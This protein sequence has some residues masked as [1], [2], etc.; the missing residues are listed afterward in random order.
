MSEDP[1]PAATTASGATPA[2]DTAAVRAD[3]MTVRYQG[4]PEPAVVEVSFAVEPGCGIVVTGAE[5]CGK[6]TVIRAV[7]GLILPM[8]GDLTVLGGAPFHDPALRR[9]IG[10]CPEKRAFPATMRVREGVGLVA[11]LRGVTAAGAVDAALHAAGLPADDARRVGS[12][13]V[14]DVRRVSLACALV[15]DPDVLA[16]D[17][18][19]EFPETVAALTRARGRGAA[20]VLATPDPGGFPAAVGPLVTLPGGGD[21]E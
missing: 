1:T 6:T 14:E 15:G 17:D 20:I 10:Y 19:W 13:E 4:T 5:G 11:S 2:P 3:A 7:L 12:L 8:T 21:D 16:L 18:P 9:R